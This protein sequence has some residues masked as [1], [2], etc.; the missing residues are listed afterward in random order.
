[1]AS[2]VMDTEDSQKVGL[3][4]GEGRAWGLAVGL[5]VRWRTQVREGWRAG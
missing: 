4:R 2:V 3:P 5:Q 1:M